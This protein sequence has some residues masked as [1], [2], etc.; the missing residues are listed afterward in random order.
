MAENH[1][2]LA[3]HLHHVCMGGTLVPARGHRNNTS[4]GG[5]EAAV[6][7]GHH[8]HL[9]PKLTSAAR[10]VRPRLSWRQASAKY[11]RENQAEVAACWANVMAAHC[12]VRRAAPNILAR[13]AR[14]VRR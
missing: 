14:L 8:R 4:C 2:L 3:H 5:G 10:I 12:A 7:A 1:S 9:C 13:A 11:R 6:A